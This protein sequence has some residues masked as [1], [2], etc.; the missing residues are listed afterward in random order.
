MAASLG[1]ALAAETIPSAEV[2][3][4][5]TIVAD[6]DGIAPAPY[7]NAGGLRV[8]LDSS[9]GEAIRGSAQVTLTDVASPVLDHAY[10]KA[11]FPWIVED[12]SFRLTAGKAP[13]AWGKGF[14]FNAGDPVFGAIPEVTSLSESAYRTATDW[15]AVAYA[16]LGDFSFAEAVVLPTVPDNKREL[17]SG[18]RLSLSPG[19]AL[20]QSV[21]ASWLYEREGKHQACVAF[22][23][24]LYFDFYA[25]AMVSLGDEA[26][27]ESPPV[28]ESAISFGIF[29]M[30]DVIPDIPLTVRAEGLVYPSENR[31]LWYPS[32]SAG[33]TDNLSLTFQGLI[34]GDEVTAAASVSWT[35]LNDIALSATAMQRFEKGDPE[36]SAV[37]QTRLTCSF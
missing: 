35:L 13:L 24:S 4:D 1:T 27:E 21:E 6:G 14:V 19:W 29:R 8:S 22:D 11:R 12:T 3:V 33:F 23:G 25:A 36:G 15:M 34:T 18:A 5:S 2:F 7:G 10:F 28:P 31:Q 30:F 9:G 26:A 20:L 32:L 17:R 37:I 16:P